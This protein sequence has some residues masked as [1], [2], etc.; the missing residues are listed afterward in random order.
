MTLLKVIVLSSFLGNYE[1]FK[2]LIQTVGLPCSLV[3]YYPIYS[4]YA[5]LLIPLMNII[6]PCSLKDNILDS[7]SE[8]DIF[9]FGFVVQ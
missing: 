2:D 1:I 3:I 9:S 7:L 8:F 4:K 5:F 6:A